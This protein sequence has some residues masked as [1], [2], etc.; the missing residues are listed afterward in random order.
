MNVNCAIK[1]GHIKDKSAIKAHISLLSCVLL[2][3]ISFRHERLLVIQICF[4]AGIRCMGRR[5]FIYRCEAK[6]LFKNDS[7]NY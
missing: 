2:I 5:A 6:S 3:V 7:M 4:L 1:K